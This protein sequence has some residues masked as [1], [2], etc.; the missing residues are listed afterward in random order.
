[1]KSPT[2]TILCYGD[3]N[4]YG[5][6]PQNGLR[7]PKNIR[8]TG[9]LQQLLGNNYTVIEEGCNGRTTVYEDVNEGW[10]AGLP[11]LKPCLNSHKPIDIVILMLGSND[12]KNCFHA[13]A[14]EI[15]NGAERLVEE[16]KQFSNE[17]QGFCPAIIL[18]APPI[19]GENICNTHFRYAFDETAITRSKEFAQ[20]YKEVADRQHCIF[21]NAAEHIVSSEVDG[22]HLMP[23]EHKKLAKVLSLCI[24]R[25]NQNKINKPDDMKKEYEKPELFLN[26]ICR[27]YRAFFETNNNKKRAKLMSDITEILSMYDIAE[28]I[29]L[30]NHIRESL[31]DYYFY[32]NI[33]WKKISAAKN[34]YPYL[35]DEEYYYFII[36]GS[37]HPN[38]YFRQ[39]CI[40]QMA[41]I[42]NTLPYIILRIN[43][44]VGMVQQEAYNAALNRI[45]N[46]SLEELFQALPVMLKVKNSLRRKIQY[47]EKTEAL[48]TKYLIE[49]IPDIEFKEIINYP[50]SVRNAF[51]R[52]ICKYEVLEKS[53]MEQ[54]MQIEKS[55][56]A[57]RILIHTIIERYGLQEADYNRYKKDKSSAV[58]R[59]AAE[60]WYF[61]KKDVW[62]GAE[63]LLMDECKSIRKL[64][65]F[66][67]QTH[68][69]L[70]IVDFYL[71]ELK[72]QESY[73]AILG[74]GESGEKK[75]A[76]ALYPYLQ[77]KQTKIVKAALSSLSNL[78]KEDGEKLYYQYL[79]VQ[80]PALVRIAYL[81]SRKWDIHHG[82]DFLKQ[83]FLKMD[84]PNFKRY[85]LLL[86]IREPGWKKVS[87]L[88][89]LCTI[90]EE[91]YYSIIRSG[92]WVKSMYCSLSDE[93]A[94]EIEQKLEQH[95]NIFSQHE[96]EIIKLEL[97]HA[98]K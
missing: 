4:T 31:F 76:E 82:A 38:G 93:L 57:K 2:T 54:I 97:K 37:F 11:Y 10:K 89:D 67:F 44:W 60:S 81:S 58:R 94:D 18:I 62:L 83:L 20:Y 69:D 5:Y 72:K 27:L 43:D 42:D 80:E 21:V 92:L 50:L 46:A 55:I 59:Y 40:K 64:A 66:M 28:M 39:K 29:R 23:S 63:E 61:L 1:M 98:R 77:S 35:N 87:V 34:N 33:N 16:I 51:Y 91:P 96:Y 90:H 24:K 71:S 15:S 3:S 14:K 30:D 26:R 47:L 70:S 6:N 8:W 22:L 19:I 13:S 7:Y 53:K 88:L 75:H 9:H 36:L 56:F 52:F 65:H 84:N 79:Q 68:T 74:I 25:I 32:H 73:I 41:T 95:R 49:Y 45:K 85:A 86:L 78:L 12:L 17:K 48:I